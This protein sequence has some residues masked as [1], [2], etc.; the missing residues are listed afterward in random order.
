MIAL[1]LG[2]SG[3]GIIFQFLYFLGF[4]TSTVHLG[5]PVGVAAKIPSL[6]ESDQNSGQEFNFNYSSVGKYYVYFIRLFGLLTVAFT[7]IFILFSDSL[8]SF[9]VGE[10]KYSLAFVIVLVSAPF[11]VVYSIFE[12]FLKCYGK[13]TQIVVITI[14]G[15]LS[16]ILLL[17]PLI[18]KFGILGVSIYLFFSGFIPF[19]IY[20]IKNWQWTKQIFVIHKKEKLE[21]KSQILK[22]GSVSLFSSLL[23]IG[24]NIII[25][26]FTI[27][28]LGLTNNGIYQSIAALSNSSFLI[29]YYYLST[30]L[31]PKISSLHTDNEICNE[32]DENFRFILLFIVPFVIVVF[33][34]RYL[35][36]K[37]LFSSDFLPAVGI[38]QYQFLGDFFR[39]LSGLFGLWMISRMKLFSIMIIDLIMNIIL[40]S[41]PF[42]CKY[43]FS[44]ISLIV[45]PISYMIALFVH[46]IL[47][48]IVTIKYINYAAS[49]KA[50][51][52]FIISVFVLTVAFLTSY[53]GNYAEYIGAPFLVIIY[54]YLS[55]SLDEREKT[56]KLIKKY[57]GNIYSRIN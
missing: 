30:Y 32:I 16:S 56:I 6:I 25:R 9:L 35:L 4:F 29:F 23:F 17:Y 22:T 43:L 21:Y 28:N 48:F 15:S 7:I 2:P 52:T 49:L 34:Y 47:F 33:S 24:S 18:T 3:Y 10:S 20:C 40:I 31:L 13:F 12:S 8:T 57:T 27:D 46:F 39:C 37:L 51:K 1:I 50:K 53:L 26:K 36:I 41:S 45:I 11:A 5:T 44:E 19:L 42:L 54:W 55:T 38:I 14:I